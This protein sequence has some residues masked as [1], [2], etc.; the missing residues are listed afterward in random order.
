VSIHE[1]GTGISWQQ[2]VTVDPQTARWLLDT[3]DELYRWSLN[4]ALTPQKAKERAAQLGARLWQTFIG[5]QGEAFLGAI[6]PTAVLLDVDETILNLPWEL[7][8]RSGASLSQKTPFGRLVTTRV[9]PR[10]GRD[11]LKED[12]I[13][14]I[15]AVGNPTGDLP[16]GER[17]VAGLQD[18]AGRHAGLE[19]QVEVLSGENATRGA[20]R[21]MLAAADYDMLHFAGHGNLEPSAPE[22][23]F[24]AF[25]DGPLSAEEVI[26]LP[27]KAPPY[28]VFNSACESGRAVGGRRLV[29]DRSHSNGLA[30]AFLAAGAYAYAGYFFPVTE[31]GAVLF[32]Q[33]FYRTLFERENVGLAFLQARRVAARELSEVGD[34]TGLSA[35]L[36]GDAASE[37]RRD[38]AM[39]V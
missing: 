13:L 32:A 18:L 1:E 12:A 39:A 23:S 20:F 10:A 4:Q 35:V 2:N 25:A 31:T 14:R 29:S 37:H 9:V 30:A 16:V 11:P 8:G 22:T 38:L 27:W 19:I 36:Y 15:L 5:P 17:E 28:L 3:T 7:I 34:L 21:E 26:A 24:L 33:Q 6:V